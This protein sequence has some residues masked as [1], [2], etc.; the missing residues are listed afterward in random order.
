MLRVI[1][2]EGVLRTLWSGAGYDTAH[3]AEHREMSAAKAAVFVVDEWFLAV[4]HRADLLG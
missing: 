2:G 1:A 3:I 4:V